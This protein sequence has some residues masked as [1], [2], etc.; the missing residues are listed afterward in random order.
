MTFDGDVCSSV[1][2]AEND[3]FILKYPNLELRSN[4]FKLIKGGNFASMI[5][6]VYEN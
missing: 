2:N 1:N 5:K 4:N 6:Q 3:N